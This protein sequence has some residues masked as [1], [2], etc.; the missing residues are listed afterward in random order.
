MLNLDKIL[1][2]CLDEFKNEYYECEFD[3]NIFVEMYLC[4]FFKL[5]MWLNIIMFGLVLIKF[6]ILWIVL[7]DVWDFLIWCF[8]YEWGRGLIVSKGKL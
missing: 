4:F 6:F 3:Y 1:M 8:V 2:L 5:Y 7:V